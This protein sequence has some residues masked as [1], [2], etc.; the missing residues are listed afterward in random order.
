MAIRTISLNI[1]ISPLVVYLNISGVSQ[2]LSGGRPR[3]TMRNEMRIA[4]K[5]RQSNFLVT[6][7]KLNAEVQR[8]PV[9]PRVGAVCD[10]SLRRG[11]VH[12]RVGVVFEWD[13]F[14][15]KQNLLQYLG[16]VHAVLNGAKTPCTPTCRGPF[17]KATLSPCSSTSTCSTSSSCCGCT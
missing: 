2:Y 11:P 17:T 4:I 12:Q 6:S 16:V 5:P 7:G 3:T 1:W 15:F 14:S 13:S 9:H 8:R 10:E